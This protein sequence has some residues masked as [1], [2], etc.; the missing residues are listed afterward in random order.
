MAVV[1][2]NRLDGL[3]EAGGRA[4]G[5]PSPNETSTA[6]ERLARSKK[7]QGQELERA[8][9]C[10]VA[11]RDARR[12]G[13]DALHARLGVRGALGV[14][15][16]HAALVEGPVARVEDVGVA[17]HL[18]GIVLLAIDRDRARRAQK[19]R[20]EGIAEER[21]RGQVVDFPRHD[22]AHQHRVDEVVRMIHA[23]E[24]G[25]PLGHAL[26]MVGVDAL[27][28]EPHPEPRDPPDRLIEAVH[29][30]HI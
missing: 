30:V 1:R 2:L 22:R 6:R 20:E 26:A 5:Q 17:V 24:H 23:E 9:C 12:A 7:A 10:L 18:V 28:Q 4:S 21:R 19:A 11:E 13:L 14:D 8:G 25:T 15:R 3:P 29:V 27:E 16:D